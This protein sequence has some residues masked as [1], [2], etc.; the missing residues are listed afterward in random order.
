MLINITDGFLAGM[1]VSIGGAVL[2][3]CDN[4]YVGACMFTIALLVICYRGYSLY[5]GK[6]GFMAESHTKSDFSA[7]GF[8]LLGNIIGTLGCGLALSYAFPN[9]HTKAAAMCD[10]RLAQAFPV[11]LIRAV[12][13]GILMYTAVVIYKENKSV[14]GVLFCVPVFI[15]SGFEHSI[16]DMFYLDAALRYSVRSVAFILTVILG[17]SIG[18][19]LVPI[20]SNIKA[21][22]A[23]GKN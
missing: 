2:L 17:N 7:L 21:V 23:N 10:A 8:G 13:C 1:M 9:I 4:R 20:L 15:L 11:T 18:G 14:L 5:T 12:F 16:A 22:R 6:I 19:L 3:S